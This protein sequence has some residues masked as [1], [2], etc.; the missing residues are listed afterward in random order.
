MIKDARGDFKSTCWQ[1]K[2]SKCLVRMLDDV[3]TTGQVLRSGDGKSAV[4]FD[5]M[6]WQ[7]PA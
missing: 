4:G 2:T 7:C 6:V 5:H 1:V 3:R